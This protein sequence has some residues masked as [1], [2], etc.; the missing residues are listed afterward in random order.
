MSDKQRAEA[1]AEGQKRKQQLDGDLVRLQAV[2]KKLQKTLLTAKELE[3][4]VDM[5]PRY[6][7]KADAG[8]CSCYAM[9]VTAN[10]KRLAMNVE[11][12]IETVK[13]ERKSWE[14][15]NP[16]LQT[17]NVQKRKNT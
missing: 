14:T 16:Y 6:E 12:M 5:A 13:E 9:N 1:I 2:Q 10:L 7:T 8:L 11:K 4:S 3:E 17:L 15:V